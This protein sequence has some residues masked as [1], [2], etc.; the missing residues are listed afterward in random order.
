MK[1]TFNATELIPIGPNGRRTKKVRHFLDNKKLKLDPSTITTTQGRGAHT[2]L[3]LT[4]LPE[5]LLWLTPKTRAAL[6]EGV[7]A[8]TIRNNIRDYW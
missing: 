2:E 6:L 7:D 8:A 3:P 1:T 5:Y 4:L